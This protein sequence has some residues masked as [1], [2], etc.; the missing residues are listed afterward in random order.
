MTLT[1]NGSQLARFAG[2]LADYGVKRV[3]V[4]LDTLDPDKFRTVTRWGD[5]TGVLDGIDAAAAAG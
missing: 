2:E 1:T 5:L 4:S 3:N